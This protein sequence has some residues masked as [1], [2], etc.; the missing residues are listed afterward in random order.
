MRR[1]TVL[2]FVIMVWGSHLVQAQTPDP[3]SFFPHHEEDIWEYFNPYIP[4]VYEQNRI[5]LDSLGADGRYYIETSLFENY[6]LDTTGFTIYQLF[7]RFDKHGRRELRYK[8]DA[9]SGDYWIVYADTLV[10]HSARVV[11]VYWTYVFGS[12]LVLMKQIDYYWYGLRDIDSLLGYT[13]YLA[14]GFGLLA[15]D[16]DTFPVRRPRGTLIN[17]VLHGTV[18]SVKGKEKWNLPTQ[19]ELHQNYPNPFNPST[20]IGYELQ[21]STFVELKVHDLLGREVR[22]LVGEYQQSGPHSVL[23]NADGFASGTY[24]YTLKTSGGIKSRKMNLMR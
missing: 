9:D 15:Q 12:N 3:L 5:T 10:R 1:M 17:G 11:G 16:N 7:E 8:L 13:D 18:T 22:Q 24:F 23:F 2:G 21:H 6:I 20:L 19:S 14:S 4:G